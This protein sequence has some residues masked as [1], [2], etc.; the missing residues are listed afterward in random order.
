MITNDVISAVQELLKSGLS[1]RK[2]AKQVGIGRGTVNNIACGKCRVKQA[3]EN[4][5][6]SESESAFAFIYP[7]KRCPGCGALL[8]VWPCIACNS[9][10]D[11]G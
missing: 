2:I 11:P 6:G 9:P 1:G 3:S 10:Q 8:K 4:T 5:S 7:P